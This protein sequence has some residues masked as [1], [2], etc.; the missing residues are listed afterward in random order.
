MYRHNMRVVWLTINVI[1][2][3]ASIFNQENYNYRRLVPCIRLY[4]C[5]FEG[6]GLAGY[7]RPVESKSP[8]GLASFIEL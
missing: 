2:N 8:L 4:S 1:V 5:H 7:E 6:V 3:R